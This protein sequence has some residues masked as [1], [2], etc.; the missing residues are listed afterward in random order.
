MIATDALKAAHYNV[1]KWN[2]YLKIATEW[3]NRVFFN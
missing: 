1:M 2:N 3:L